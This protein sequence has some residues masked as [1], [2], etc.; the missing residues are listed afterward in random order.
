MRRPILRFFCFIAGVNYPVLLRCPTTDRIWAAQLGI[1]LLLSFSVIGGIAYF[2]TGYVMP[3]GPL[4]AVVALVVALTIF[5]FDRAL[6]QSDWFRREGSG[7]FWDGVQRYWPIPIRLLISF[8]LAYVLATFLELAVFSDT[9]SE[10]LREEYASANAEL[11]A[12]VDELDAELQARI[13]DRQD[14]LRGLENSLA[15]ALDPGGANDIAQQ[16][17]AL[18]QR[19]LQLTEQI[20]RLQEDANAELFGVKTQE[21]QTG[22]AGAGPAYQFAMAQIETLR[23]QLSSV[24]DQLAAH[25]ARLEEKRPAI[26]AEV[27]ELRD[28]VERLT[29]AKP[30]EVAALRAAIEASPEYS[31]L[32]DDPLARMAAF[33]RLKDD[34]VQGPT[35]KW[36][37]LLCLL[38]VGF[39][40][41]VPVLAKLLF[42]PNTAYG[43]MIRTE[44]ESARLKATHSV[45]ME[46]NE[47]RAAEADSVIDL[48]IRQKAKEMA[49]ASLNEDARAQ[50]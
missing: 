27:R 23:T 7:D 38:F 50:G 9:I 37:A 32:K 39:L 31:R 41:V 12:K 3:D 35:V 13:D 48:S 2:S 15:G 49:T 5:L 22:I 10:K 26:E 19:R 21:S 8:S 18:E 36:F 40:E 46:E 20:A 24:D 6:F 11:L 4:R 45:A 28:E 47:V 33:Q 25:E 17:L 16:R 43:A 30:I 42:S 1:S 14:L 44:I 34:P 29:V